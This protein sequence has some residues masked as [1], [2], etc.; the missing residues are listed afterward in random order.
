MG[1]VQAASFPRVCA[2]VNSSLWLLIPLLFPEAGPVARFF[3][4]YLPDAAIRKLLKVSCSTPL[5]GVLR[6]TSSL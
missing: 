1:S 6:A 4:T 5:L 3:T 2:G